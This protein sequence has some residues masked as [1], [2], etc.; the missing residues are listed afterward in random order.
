MWA[1]QGENYNNKS[2][3]DTREDLLTEWGR[4]GSFVDL[5]TWLR[6]HS[7]CIRQYDSIFN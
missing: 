6:V 1:L 2:I 5:A 7:T 3:T 4:R